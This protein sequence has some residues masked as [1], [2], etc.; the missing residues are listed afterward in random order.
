MS[1]T[2]KGVWAL[3]KSGRDAETRRRINM[4]IDI[5]TSQA[6]KP[7]DVKKYISEIST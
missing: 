4:I 5:R 2:P 3:V 6:S 7:D 1:M